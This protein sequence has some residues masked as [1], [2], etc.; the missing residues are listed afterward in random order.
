ME[1]KCISKQSW[2]KGTKPKVTI[3]CHAY[4][5]QDYIS[6]AID[7]FLMQETNFPVDIIINDDCSTDNT[8]DIIKKYHNLYPELIKPI[9]RKKNLYHKEAFSLDLFIQAE[10]HYI[11][12]CDGDDC[13]TTSNKLQIQFETLEKNPDHIFCC[14]LTKNFINFKIDKPK[15]VSIDLVIREKFNCH[16]SSFFF[17]N[18]F[19]KMNKAKLPEYL[20]YGFNGDYAL[21]VFLMQNSSCIIL[22]YIMSCYR[23]SGKGSYHSLSSDGNIGLIKK[24]QSMLHIR[25]MIKYHLGPN[26]YLNISKKNF[27]NIFSII[28][29]NIMSFNLFGLV[30]SIGVFGLLLL[31]YI[32]S[33]ILLHIQKKYKK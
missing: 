25:Q 1:K 11:A 16:S 6:N 5:H 31:E 14:H 2:R 33:S 18:V 27:I 28:K 10:G 13:W 9:Y 26:E 12:N 23:I 15:F 29:R 8:T 3:V 24:A 7:S 19:K 20:F 32:S 17:K 21:T 4:N 30:K 22:P